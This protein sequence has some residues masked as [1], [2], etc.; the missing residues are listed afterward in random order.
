MM[1]RESTF[2]NN[3]STAEGGGTGIFD[4]TG[5]VLANSTWDGN[6]AAAKVGVPVR[7][8]LLVLIRPGCCPS[9]MAFFDATEIASCWSTAPGTAT[10]W[11]PRWRA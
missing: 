11:R 7:A 8:C 3:T 2:L 4:A 9:F 1:V 5:I 10:L 6:F